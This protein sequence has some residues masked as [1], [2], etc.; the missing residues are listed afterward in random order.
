MRF[1]IVFPVVKKRVSVHIDTFVLMSRFRVADTRIS[2][3]QKIDLIMK[4]YVFPL[5]VRYPP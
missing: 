1:L 3:D 2:H 4:P 5:K